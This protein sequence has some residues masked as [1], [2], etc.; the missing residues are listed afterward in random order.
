MKQKTVTLTGMAVLFALLA[1]VP[2]MAYSSG[3]NTYPYTPYWTGG[4]TRI[5]AYTTTWDYAQGF[6]NYVSPPIASYR[7]GAPYH[8]GSNIRSPVY[9]AYS[10]R[11]PNIY[12]PYYG[13]P[14]RSY[15]NPAWIYYNY[16]RAY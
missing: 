6:F 5:G 13:Y 9:P 12:R 15:G 16:Y 7:Y 3:D 2:A 10:A 1:M 8:W 11:V 14:Y 4:Q